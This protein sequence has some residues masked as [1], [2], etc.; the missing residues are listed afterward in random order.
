MVF[1]PPAGDGSSEG[2]P[3][4]SAQT[5]ASPWFIGDRHQRLA[6]RLLGAAGA[7]PFSREMP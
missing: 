7:S 1:A 3:A 2:V 4:G 5:G 6:A